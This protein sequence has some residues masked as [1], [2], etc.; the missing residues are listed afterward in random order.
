MINERNLEKCFDHIFNVF[1]D[2]GFFFIYCDHYS[3]NF[4]TSHC[5]FSRKKETFPT[6]AADAFE[7]PEK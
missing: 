5:H 4:S 1:Y 6:S 2:T 3:V 7:K